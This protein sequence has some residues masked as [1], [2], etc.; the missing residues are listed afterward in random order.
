MTYPLHDR[1]IGGGSC[2]VHFLK[3]TIFLIARA[4]LVGLARQLSDLTLPEF[5]Q[6]LHR[7]PSMISRL[8][9]AHTDQSDRMIEGHIHRTLHLKS[10]PSYTAQ[11]RL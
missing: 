4:T 9:T 6:H 1:E 2:I 7:G 11:P 5:G 8:A 10:S 3:S